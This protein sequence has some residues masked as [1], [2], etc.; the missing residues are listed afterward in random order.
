MIKYFSILLITFCFSLNVHS[1]N[2]DE[3]LYESCLIAKKVVFGNKL[4]T[5]ESDNAARYGYCIGV[6]QSVMDINSF[7]SAQNDNETLFCQPNERVTNDELVKIFIHHV[8]QNP[9]QAKLP[10]VETVLNSYKDIFKCK[11]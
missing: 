3:F 1:R 7:L 2:T 4:I 8:D 6:L 10:E 11:K 9:E 5:E